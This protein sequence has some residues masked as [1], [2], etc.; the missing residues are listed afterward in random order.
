MRCFF[1]LFSLIIFNT[2][3]FA[4][5]SEETGCMDVA[6]LNYSAENDI[7]DPSLCEYPT[8]CAEDQQLVMI[9]IYIGNWSSEITWDIMNLE[10]IIV[11]NSPP[12]NTFYTDYQIYTTYACLNINETYSFNSYD[13]YGDGWNDNGAYQ[14]SIC[15]GGVLMADNND[16]PDY[17]ETEEFI[18]DSENCDLYGCMDETAC[19]YDGTALFP[20]FCIYP[21][22][23]Y[24]CTGN[25]INDINGNSICD[26]LDV[27]GCT[28]TSVINF[29]E[30]ATFDDGSCLYDLNCDN[31]QIQI[32]VVIS[33]DSY[34]SETSFV[35]NDNEGIV[36]ASEDEVFN[37]DYTAYP[38]QYCLPIDGCY[39]F[40][41][42]DSYGDGIFS[43]GGVQVYYEEDLVLNNPNFQ[44]N[45]SITMNC[46]PGYDCNTALEVGLGSYATETNDYWYV[47]NAEVNGQYDI[48]T[49]E[50]DC[51][52][53]IYIYD[54]C[55]GLVPS[56]YNDGTIYYND[57]LCGVQSQVFPLMEAGDTYYIRIKGDC[58]NIDWELNYIGPVQGCTDNTA[59]NFNPIAESDDGSCIYPGDPD[60]VNGPD[61]LVMP[62]E[63]S[64][65]LQAYENED[66]CAIEEGCLTG[67][68]DRSIIRFDTW[69]KNVGNVDYFIGSVSDNEETNQFEWDMCHNHWHYKGYA[70]YVLFDSDGQI[71]PVGFKNG[72]CVMDLECSGDDELGVPAGNYTYGCSV[73]G[74]SAG[75]G[76]IYGSGLSCQWIDIT[77]VPDGEYTFV[78]RTNWDQDPDAMGNIELS[79]EN[80]WEQTCIGV[81]TN[82]DG[83]KDFYMAIDI[84]GD[85]IDNINDPDIDGDGIMNGSD[86][87]SDGDGVLDDV[88]DTPYGM[89]E[90]PVYTDCNGEEFGNAQYDCNGICGGE[91]VTGDMNFDLFL[92]SYDMESYASE[93]IADDWSVNTCNDLDADGEL[94]VS[95]I[96]LLVNCVENF[97]DINR[98]NQ[99][100]PCSFGLEVTNPNDT[101]TLSIGDINLLEQY[102]DIYVLN[103]DNEILG[104]QFMM[105]NITISSVE[106]LV[107]DFDMEPSFSSDG[108][109]LGISY[110]DSLIIKN[111]DPT[112]F[113]RVYFSS[114]GENV[115]IEDIIDVVNQDY[116]NV[117]AIN[118]TESCVQ[119]INIA[120]YS[121][122]N[123]AI[124][125]NPADDLVAIKLISTELNNVDF[126][127]KSLLGQ[128]LLKQQF[129]DNNLYQ[130][131]DVS[132]LSNGIYFVELQIDNITFTE[133]IIIE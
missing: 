130:E 117:I 108:M 107:D 127:I 45:S 12:L 119:S 97:D 26:E 52:T 46:P 10:G 109:V 48:N 39:I 77:N 81:F 42:Y 120:S 51:N 121:G 104:Y 96:A 17:G 62:F 13:S 68:G 60:C 44:Y 15:D 106:N 47:F 3:L 49:C 31:N 92:D 70:E 5:D 64:M 85:G 90:C 113:C 43:G 41:L 131:I 57:D 100:E 73:M 61:L 29:D 126:S 101:V 102:V 76:D 53:V 78:V 8:E 118:N 37:A 33:T 1:T 74:I 89:S 83:V 105:G 34:P 38:F 88:D 35:L 58:D 132:H 59:C 25:C 2:F 54:Y 87:D 14:L 114:I 40:T 98:D 82:S 99:S 63:S 128:T 6:A 56:D 18:I 129:L 20:S 79:Y 69:I 94:T 32:D 27:F 11:A 22:I 91:S 7:S 95:D 21:P 72:F 122:I 36:W 103:P 125:P 116:E 84:D 9:D 112:P 19:N 111:F 55:T 50:S 24:D 75:C 93:I 30:F 124:Y 65:Y 115:C 110:Q 23:Y 123:F 28:D 80:N 133:K 16:I 4:Q 86:D 66:G 71:I 67:Y